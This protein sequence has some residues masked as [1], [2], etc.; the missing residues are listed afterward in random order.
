M[1]S[2]LPSPQR[3]YPPFPEGMNPMTFGFAQALIHAVGYSIAL[4]QH[5]SQRMTGKLLLIF[6]TL[7][8]PFL[9]I[10]FDL[11]PA[12]RTSLSPQQPTAPYGQPPMEFRRAG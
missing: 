4:L 7:P 10:F 6:A 1:A 9:V 5:I 11:P 3:H 8:S 12:K 2:H